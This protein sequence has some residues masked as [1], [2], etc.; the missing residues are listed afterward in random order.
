MPVGSGT[1][2]RTPW[3]SAHGKR[4]IATL[5][6]S[7]A[8]LAACS[9]ESVGRSGSTARPGPDGRIVVRT[10]QVLGPFDRRL[11]GTNVPAWLLPE[12]VANQEFRDLTVASGTTLLRLPGGSWSSNYDWMGCELGDPQRCDATWAMRPSDFL[13]LLKATGLPAMWTVSMNGTAQEAAALVAFFNGSVD[14]DHPIGTD[15]N[16]F[17]WLTVGHWAQLR[18]E[19]GY[20]EPMPIRYW[21]IGNEVYGAKESAGKNC[22]SFGWEDVWT[23]D[24]TE[25]VTGTGDHDG[26]LQFREAMRAVDPDIEVGAVGVGDR[27]AF[28]HWDDAVMGGAGDAIDFYIVHHYGSNGDPPAEDV[29]GLPGND[30]PRITG[31]VRDGFGDHGIGS[32]VPIAVT[33]HNLVAFIDGD[34]EKLM[35]TGGQR[36]L[37]G[38]DDRADGGERRHDREPVE[39]GQRPGGERRATTGCSTPRPTSA[40]RRTTRWFCGLVSATNASRSKLAPASDSSVSTAGAAPMDRP[41]C[42]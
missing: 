10:D 33:E 11:L 30:W 28:N 27:S 15:R 26:F 36:L 5:L 7:L 41:G 3:L 37:P 13:G 1:T 32:D 40:A 24:G 20:P 35:T 39:P 9:S 8:L 38:R 42:S 2:T 31:D 18:A 6:A 14:D 16:G 12:L 25:Y 22:A 4:W 21:E 19:R 23:C 34:D 17:D 29:F